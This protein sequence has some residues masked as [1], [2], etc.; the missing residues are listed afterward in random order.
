MRDSEASGKVNRP[1]FSVNGSKVSD[2][3]GVILR[4]FHRVF[5]AGVPERGG[6]HFGSLGRPSL[7]CGLG[8]FG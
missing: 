6:L 3:F 8:T 4:R 2:G 5:V 7:P 1:R